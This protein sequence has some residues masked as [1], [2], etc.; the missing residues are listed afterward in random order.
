METLFLLALVALVIAGLAG[1]VWLLRRTG[2][3]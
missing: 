3:L 2:N 1:F